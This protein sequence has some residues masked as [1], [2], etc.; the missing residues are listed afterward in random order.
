M[1]CRNKPEF[2]RHLSRRDKGGGINKNGIQF[3]IGL[4]L[5]IQDKQAGLCRDSYANIIIDLLSGAAIER[6]V[7]ETDLDEKL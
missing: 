4:A 3:W 5:L 7:G 1:V 2:V 6:F